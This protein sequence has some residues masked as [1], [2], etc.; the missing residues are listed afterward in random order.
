MGW[1]A[2]C[3]TGRGRRGRR[4]PEG[5]SGKPRGCFNSHGG[6]GSPKGRRR[7]CRR[8][9][10]VGAWGSG[11]GAG[12]CLGRR[13]GSRR[14]L[15]EAARSQMRTALAEAA[16]EPE[17]RRLTREGS[18]SSEGARRTREGSGR[19]L[20]RRSSVCAPTSTARPASGAGR[21][22]RPEEMRPGSKALV[23]EKWRN[24]ERKEMRKRRNGEKRHISSHVAKPARLDVTSAKPPGETA[25]GGTLSGFA[26]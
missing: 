15:V 4:D 18:G 10:P 25:G 24:G 3:G 17:G 11:A 5:H 6:G 13:R 22:R 1:T 12:G 21:R 23:G 16:W 26:T 9:N 8:R 14:A 20:H 7:S 19:W 2:E